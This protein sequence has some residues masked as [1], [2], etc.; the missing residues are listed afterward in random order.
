MGFLYNQFDVDTR[1][2]AAMVFVPQIWHTHSLC[3]AA[4]EG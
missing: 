1:D 2:N 4:D 3:E